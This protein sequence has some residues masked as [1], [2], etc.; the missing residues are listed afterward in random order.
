VLT[1]GLPD[2][3]ARLAAGKR[4]QA[5]AQAR[6]DTSAEAVRRA[7]DACQ[8]AA[9]LK[10]SGLSQPATL[11]LDQTNTAMEAAQGTLSTVRGLV[12]TTAQVISASRVRISRAKRYLEEEAER[13]T[14][15]RLGT[16]AVQ[17]AVARAAYPGLIDQ[18]DSFGFSKWLRSTLAQPG[19]RVFDFQPHGWLV[20]MAEAMPSFLESEAGVRAT[21]AAWARS[22]SPPHPLVGE[23]ASTHLHLLAALEAFRLTHPA[24]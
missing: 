20:A 22:D 18:A 11:A 16:A 5:T 6:L 7:Q 24:K 13:D 17:A 15:A 23:R 3:E 9:I 1:A 10:V 12:G 4:Q 8:D 21:A 2:M 19:R 14:L